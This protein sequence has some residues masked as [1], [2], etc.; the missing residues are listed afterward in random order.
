MLPT[1]TA[2]DLCV[3]CT[4]AIVWLCLPPCAQSAIVA[5]GM[6]LCVAGSVF[7]AAAIL[8]VHRSVVNDVGVDGIVQ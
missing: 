6:T 3:L 5:C 1:P 8:T 2:R 4:T 7:V